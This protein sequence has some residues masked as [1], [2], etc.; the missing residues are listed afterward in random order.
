MAVGSE[1]RGSRFE[2]EDAEIKLLAV[3]FVSKGRYS[4]SLRTS[5]RRMREHIVKGV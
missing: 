3:A 1:V 4:H 5:Y 2:S